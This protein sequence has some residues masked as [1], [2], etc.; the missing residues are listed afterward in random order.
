MKAGRNIVKAGS[1]IGII[2]FMPWL[3]SLLPPSWIGLDLLENEANAVYS[4][5]EVTLSCYMKSL[6]YN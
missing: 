3:Q 4:Y 1:T 2:G 6:M 5:F